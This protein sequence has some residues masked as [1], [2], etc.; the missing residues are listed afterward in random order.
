MS[1][2]ELCLKLSPRLI[3]PPRGRLLDRFDIPVGGNNQNWR[4]LLIA[5]KMLQDGALERHVDARYAGWKDGFGREV[6]DGKLGL[7]AVAARVLSN[8]TDT[9]PGSGRQEYL[10]N[11]VNRFCSI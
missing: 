9:L 6:L 2:F 3:A 8:N 4:A 5:E 11:L 10:E 1:Y 7:D